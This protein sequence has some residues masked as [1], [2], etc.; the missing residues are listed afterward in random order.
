MHKINKSY[1]GLKSLFNISSIIVLLISLSSCQIKNWTDDKEKS[2][3]KMVKIERYDRLESRY[4]TT[5]DYSALQSMNTDY[6]I[7]TRTLIENVLEL[8]TVDQHDI[9]ERFLKFYQDTTLQT[10]INDVETQYVSMDDVSKDLSYSF[11]R[12]KHELPQIQ[13]PGF[14]TQIGALNQS[15][16]IGD[17]IIG[18]S[19]DKYLGSDYHVYK[20]YYEK[21]Q[22]ESMTRQNIVPDCLTFFIL[23]LYPLHNFETATQETRDAHIGKVFW[24]VNKVMD[25]NFYD[26]P[27][28]RKTAKYMS[29]HRKVSV[30]QLLEMDK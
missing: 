1:S 11:T 5:G 2:A 4:L 19:L 29:S 27:E 17:G 9:S 20:R 8:G 6:P 23:S 13:I 10:I 21:R 26:T 15:I 22:I 3:D 28:V 12:L 14:Y 7:E 30:K 24:V 18:I 16:I 25:K